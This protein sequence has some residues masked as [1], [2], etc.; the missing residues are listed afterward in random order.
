MVIHLS[1]LAWEIP[2]IEEPGR[3]QSMGHKRVGYD[4]V[5]KHQ[6]HGI[7][8]LA[9]ILFGQMTCRCFKLTQAHHSGACPGKQVI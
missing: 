5:T 4:L 6:F 1:I 3:L 2:W 8:A 9:Y 7:A